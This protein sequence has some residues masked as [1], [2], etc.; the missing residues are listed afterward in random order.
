MT[1]YPTNDRQAKMTHFTANTSVKLLEMP[2]IPPAECMI[3]SGHVTARFS[4]QSSN[5]AKNWACESRTQSCRWTVS[6][7]KE[8][9]SEVLRQKLKWN[10]TCWAAGTDKTQHTNPNHC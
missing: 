4:E 10:G 2:S 7:K 3:R 9:A 5:G 1:C 6:V 8:E